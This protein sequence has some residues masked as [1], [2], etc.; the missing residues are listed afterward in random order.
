MNY[1]LFLQKISRGLSRLY[2]M[3]VYRLQGLKYGRGSYLGVG[4][5]FTAPKKIT[6][7]GTVSF[8]DG[9]RMWTELPN[10]E[11]SQLIIEDG[12]Q[13]NR[14]VLL[15][16]TG[17]LHVKKGVLISEGAIIYTHTHGY[18]PRQ[19]PIGNYLVIDEDV[20]VGTRSIILPSVSHIGARSIIGAGVVVSKNVPEDSIVVSHSQRILKKRET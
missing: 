11:R 15:D 9:V 8:A 12:V 16:F 13:I 20:W 2:F 5:R 19:K 10:D 17:Y 3:L 7:N 18:N 6:V 4:I 1:Y 14:N